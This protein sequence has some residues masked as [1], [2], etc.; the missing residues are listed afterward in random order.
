VTQPSRWLGTST[1]P[2]DLIE[3]VSGVQIHVI[4]QILNQ[5]PS[6]QF[7]SCALAPKRRWPRHVRG[8]RDWLTRKP[9]P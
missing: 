4:A 1:C 2:P 9:N 3:R 5:Q 8:S 6:L 7:S